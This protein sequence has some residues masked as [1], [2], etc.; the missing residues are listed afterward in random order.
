ML[1]RICHKLQKH[2]FVCEIRGESLTKKLGKKLTKDELGNHYCK[3]FL[4]ELANPV[5]TKIYYM[6]VAKHDLTSSYQEFHD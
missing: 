4:L 2:K 1:S 5:L 3:E 6:G